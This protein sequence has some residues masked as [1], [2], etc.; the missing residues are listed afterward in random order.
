M[1]SG[2]NAAWAVLVAAFALAGCKKDAPAGPPP[3]AQSTI[4]IPPQSSVIAVPVTADLSA[5]GTA[6]EREGPRT[7]WTINRK[8]ETCI[9]SERVKVAFVKLK[10]PRIECDIV[11]R[12]TRGRL[13]FEGRGQQIVVTMPIHAEVRAQDIGGVLKQETATA[14]AQVRAVV[15]IALNRDWS[16]RGT[17]DIRYDWTDPPH[18]D[19]LGQRIE[20]TS[21]ADARLKDVVARL[22]RSLPR[23]IA[24]VQ[25]RGEVERLWKKAFTSLQ[26]NES[27]PPVWMRIAPQ[28]LQ[29]GGFTLSGKRIELQLGLKAR[30]ETFVGDRPA[31]PPATPLPPLEELDGEP[32]KLVFF[33]PVIADYAQ[34]E[35]VIAEALAKRAQRPFTLPGIGAVDARFGKVEAYGAP[36]GRLAV[37]VTFAATPRDRTIGSASGTVWL[38]ARPVNA[39]NSRKVSFRDLEITGD[40]D[41]A[42]ADLLLDLANSP[43]FSQ[44]IA[45]ALAQNFE[46]DYD[47]LLAKI[48]RA[49]D[50][51]REGDLLIRATIE[52]VQ[53]GRLTAAGQGLYLPVRGTG[54]ASI[55]LAPR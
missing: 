31:D 12:V 35:P 39:R 17:V 33:I 1:A 18:I 36:G 14:D 34:L 55:T 10:T 52:D 24:K 21:E 4:E 32:G 27:N 20:F 50:N 7:L 9:A 25:L 37:G 29:Y 19:F 5:L 51:K 40:T 41:R 43:G 11:G 38:T 3:R 45:R 26:L 48:E 15:D 30:T 6:L 53:T 54:T 49:I 8:D 42:G 2:R 28:E 16:P 23:E 44:T 47:E 46:D 13:T 22:E